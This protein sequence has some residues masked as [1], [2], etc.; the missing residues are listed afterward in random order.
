MPFGFILKMLMGGLNPGKIF[1]FIAK[2]WKQ[3]IVAAMAGIIFYQNF[4]ETR[5][6]FGSET[7]PSL[8]KRL[9][10]S[11]NNLK[12]CANDNEL[13]SGK[14]EEN[15]NRI[16]VYE[17]LTKK[18]EDARVVLGIELQKER[19]KTDKETEVILKDPAPKTCEKAIDYLRKGKDDLKW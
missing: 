15:N 2:Y 12:T 13:L 11:Q 16:K 5:F 10:E 18:L 1:E 8:E 4:F 17:K 19:K 6:I 14:I 3:M 7:I 9:E